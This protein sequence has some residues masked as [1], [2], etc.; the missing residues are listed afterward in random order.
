MVNVVRGSGYSDA[1]VIAAIY[2]YAFH[3]CTFAEILSRDAACIVRVAGYS[4]NC[5]IAAVFAVY[6]LSCRVGSDDTSRTVV[7]C[8]CDIVC[9][10]S[11]VLA[12]YYTSL[13]IPCG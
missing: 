4:R 1:G 11:A 5:H 9:D 8:A 10:S 3:R 12:I 2:N 6:Q 13:F 7:F